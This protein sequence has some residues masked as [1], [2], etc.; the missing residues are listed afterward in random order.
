MRLTRDLL[1]VLWDIDH[2]L[3]ETRG[4]GRQ[5]YEQ[6]F[7][8]V[9]GQSV[10]H[11]VEVTG[12]TEQAI[13]AEALRVHGIEQTDDLNVEYAAELTRQYQQHL[14]ELRS[15]GRALPG[16][17]A[18]VAALANMPDVVQGVLTGNL[19]GVARIKLEAFGLSSHI[20]LEA[21]AY[22][23]DDRQRARLV[24]VAQRRAG[25]KYAEKFSH[26]NTVIVGDSANDV[27][28]A[29]EGGAKII[30]V[31]SGRDTEGTLRQAGA[32]IVLPDLVDEAAFVSA[33]IDEMDR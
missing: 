21:A 26:R 17:A 33:L 1:L 24:A 2:T 32:E 12:Q 16:A 10:E 4:V 13:F 31:A 15:R 9:T 23:D 8:Q 20:D 30:A 19:R 25:A 29:H 11:E 18:A 6:A 22:G 28:A 3:I 27:I 7:Q 14:D 5:L